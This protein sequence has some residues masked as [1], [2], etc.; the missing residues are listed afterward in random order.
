MKIEIRMSKVVAPSDDMV[1]DALTGAGARTES[2]EDWREDVLEAAPREQ[3]D[4]VACKLD[5]TD[6]GLNFRE[7][8][9]G[10]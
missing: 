7:N 9:Y 1:A 10:I 6:F 2:D 8:F 4:S 3:I 5:E